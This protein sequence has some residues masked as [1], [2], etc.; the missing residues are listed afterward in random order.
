MTTSGICKLFCFAPPRGRKNGSARIRSG[1]KMCVLLLLCAA[2]TI[3]SAQTFRTLKSF[4]EETGN[5]REAPL[6]Q[7]L[8][9]N[10]Y[11]T[12]ELGGASNACNHGCGTV[13][14][15]TPEG[16]PTTL[17]MFNGTDGTNP[18]AGL[19]QA[20]D[21]N[22]Y[23]TTY[24]GG[25]N[26]S[27]CGGY[28]CGTVFKITPGGKLTTLHSF[29][30]QTNC[31]DGAE[32]Y[33]GLV[34]GTDG[35]F[36]GTTVQGGALNDG[37]VF[38]ISAAGT[39]T[40]LYSFCSQTNCSDGTNPRAGL[41][42]ATDGN[43][44]GTTLAGGTSGGSGDG[45]V[46]QITAKGVLTTLH[47][48]DCTDGCAPYSGLLQGTD[49]DFYGTTSYGG[50][51]WAGAVF[52]LGVGLGPFVKTQPTSGYAGT[53]VMILGNN[54]SGTTKVE[55]NRMPADFTVVTNSEIMSSI[56]PWDVT[57]G[58][59]SVVT[60]TGTLKSNVIFRVKPQIYGFSPPSGPV[61]TEV[62]I[63]GLSLTQ[64]KTVTFGGVKTTDF[65]VNADGQVTVYVPSGAKKGH[66]A[67]TTSGGTV[68]SSG[69]FTVT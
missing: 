27:A 43:F 62:V 25:A 32:P 35:N 28:G 3:A 34:Q 39:L 16:N 46:F 50:A 18:T 5:D 51:N 63:T 64:T 41:I 68:T 23:G 52:S 11:G 20:T 48:F 44:Y 13:F 66:I 54:L 6:V 21:G 1:W 17:H 22:L 37:T 10:F 55:F 29:C 7:G 49:G 56:P 40:T 57:T 36:Y 9:G 26:S 47:S 19:V 53:A 30:S 65:I 59:V 42:Q 58:S 24:Y 45:T 31:T 33:A 61:G 8:D 60:P 38:K 4:K 2:G 14:K 67:I 69:I 12:T 15:I